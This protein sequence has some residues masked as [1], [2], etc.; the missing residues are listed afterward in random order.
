MGDRAAAHCTE[1]HRTV[2]GLVFPTRRCVLPMLDGR[3]GATPII[4]IDLGDITVG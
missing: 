2:S 4:T 1:G 3:L